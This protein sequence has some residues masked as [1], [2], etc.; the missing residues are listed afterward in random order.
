MFGLYRLSL[1][2]LP[3][4]Q[5]L[6][7]VWFGTSSGDRRNRQV[8]GLYRLSLQRFPTLQILFKVWFVQDFC[9]F[10][11]RF[12][13]VSLYNKNYIQPNY[14]LYHS[15]Y[16]VLLFLCQ[17]FLNPVQLNI[18]VLHIEYFLGRMNSVIFGILSLVY[19]LLLLYFHAAVQMDT[20]HDYP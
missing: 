11:V 5:I 2:R 12:R 3:T 1:Q 15:I 20:L 19:I 6:F 10:S 18:E 4:S 14:Y 9:L 16:Q 13:Q 8:F 7:K 17:P